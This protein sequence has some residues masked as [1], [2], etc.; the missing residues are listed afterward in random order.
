MKKIEYICNLCGETYT[1]KQAHV[2]K[3]IKG[4]YVIN[5]YTTK[6]PVTH[7]FMIKDLPCECDRHICKSCIQDICNTHTVDDM[8]PAKEYPKSFDIIVNGDTRHS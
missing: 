2:E 3:L 6:D 1:I 4:F 7:N 8:L 5:Q